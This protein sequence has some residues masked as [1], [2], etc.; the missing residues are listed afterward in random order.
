MKLTHF[1]PESM[2][3]SRMV[4]AVTG[5][6][7]LGVVAL[8]SPGRAEGAPAPSPASELGRW[9]GS[10]SGKGALRAGKDAAA[11]TATWACRETSGTF[12][13]SCEL[14]VMGIPGLAVYEEAD[15]F[16]YEAGSRTYHWYSVTNAGETHDHVASATGSGPRVFVYR[17]SRDGKA[18]EERIELRFSDA[19]RQLVGRAETRVAGTIESV[20]ELTLG[21]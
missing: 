9:I 10:W 16:G 5:A 21:K 1:V 8:A 19:G 17:G 18:L 4:A 15:L 13:V 3:S 2:F 7:A 14:R 11:L 20:M 6:V 12:G